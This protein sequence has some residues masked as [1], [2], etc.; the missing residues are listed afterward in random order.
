MESR[1]VLSEKEY[2][3]LTLLWESENGLT[4]VQMLEREPYIFKNATYVHRTLN[5]LLKKGLIVENGS[6]QYGKQYARI[7]FPS[8]TR[9]EY[10]AAAAIENGIG[11][12]S[13]KD[14]TLALF[15]QTTHNTSEEKKEAIRKLQEVIDSIDQD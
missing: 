11:L 6:I 12:H 3:I 8:M 4:S 1:F 15:K 10:A 13:L 9:E 5:V 2:T 14:F 7:F